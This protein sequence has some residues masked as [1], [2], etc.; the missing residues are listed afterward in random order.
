MSEW[1]KIGA[2][3]ALAAICGY[4]LWRRHEDTPAVRFLIC[5]AQGKDCIT[6]ARFRD[7]DGCLFA[8]R[9]FDARCDFSMPGRITCETGNVSTISS[10]T[11][12]P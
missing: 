5:D 3:L 6:Y 2:V 10:A 12:A 9:F 11:C 7:L 1:L 8:K 4:L